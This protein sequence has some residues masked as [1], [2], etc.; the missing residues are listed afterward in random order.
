MHSLSSLVQ[1][2]A[3]C[4]SQSSHRSGRGLCISPSGNEDHCEG[5]GNGYGDGSR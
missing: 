3:L 4:S 5:L 1:Q 2:N